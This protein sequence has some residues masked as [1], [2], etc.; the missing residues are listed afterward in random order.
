[1][2]TYIVNKNGYYFTT[3]LSNLF[4]KAKSL[5]VTTSLEAATNK[6]NEIQGVGLTTEEVENTAFD[7]AEKDG[8]FYISDVC[9]TYH[10]SKNPVAEVTHFCL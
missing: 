1:M 8:I 4:T 10:E 9:E 5:F 7:I 6:V 3:E 2:T